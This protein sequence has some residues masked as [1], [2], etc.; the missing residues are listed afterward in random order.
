[1]KPIRLK[2]RFV[3]FT[4][5][6]ARSV[7]ML[8]LGIVVLT[9]ITAGAQPITVPNY[10]FEFQQAPNVYP[11]VNVNVDSWQKAAEPAYY[12]PAIGIPFGIPWA[13]TAGVFLDVNPYANHVGSQAGYMLGFPEVSLSQDYNSSPT[14][15]FNATFDVG[16]SYNLTIGVFGKN[17]LAT[18]ST[19]RLS[20][21]YLDGANNPLTVGATTITYSAANFPVTNPLN[22]I[23]FQV[24]V[25]T[26]QAGDAWAGKH[27]GIQLLST[28][29]LELATGG[30][31]DFD[32]VRLTAVPEPAG[33]ALLSLGGV[34]L[35]ARIRLR[36]H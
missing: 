24:N 14:H 1:M 31:W 11:Y 20:L 29:P 9:C 5:S 33:V 16:K 10:S 3:T 34:L 12:G 4:K 27:I 26:V 28:T 36:K 23:D 22:L 21:Y 35:M 15:D 25:P 7:S 19:L 6:I 13:G 18:G 32:N 30:N 17:T 2:S 8:P